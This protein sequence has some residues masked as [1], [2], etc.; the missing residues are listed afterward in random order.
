MAVDDNFLEDSAYMPFIFVCSGMYDYEWLR[1]CSAARP[2]G[3]AVVVVRLPG[4]EVEG[5]FL[6]LGVVR[7]TS[8][9]QCRD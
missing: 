9:Y 4:S 3:K 7:K 2:A 1:A 6:V 8:G 5:S